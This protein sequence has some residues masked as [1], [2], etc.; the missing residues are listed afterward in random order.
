MKDEACP[1]LVEGDEGRRQKA[2]G[3]RE[4]AERGFYDSCWLCPRFTSLRVWV[5]VYFSAIHHKT[6]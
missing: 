4:K 3:R 6:Q 1:E 5:R 2:E